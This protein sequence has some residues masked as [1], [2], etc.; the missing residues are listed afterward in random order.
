MKNFK[1]FKMG[2]YVVAALFA[3]LV[4]FTSCNND[5]VVQSDQ[6]T[7]EARGVLGIKPA[8][9]VTAQPLSCAEDLAND[10]CNFTSGTGTDF[11]NQ[12]TMVTLMNSCR[13]EAL[14]ANC[15]WL[16]DT[17]IRTIAVDLNNCC[18]NGSVLNAQMN[19]WKQAAIN[20]RPASDYIITGY[21]R[22]NGFMMNYPYGPYRMEVNVTYRKKS[23]TFIPIGPIHN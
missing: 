20:A 21:Q 8:V 16:N 9:P 3:G 19:G 6:T 4:F 15:G 10:G 1:N 18:Y 7:T 23:C 17:Q 14:P 22:V 5:D 12:Y 2:S 11:Q 13:T